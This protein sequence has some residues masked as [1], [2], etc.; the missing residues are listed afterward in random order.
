MF[1]GAGGASYSAVESLLDAGAKVNV[2]NRTQS[3]AVQMHNH[4][5]I[6]YTL[7][8]V[9]GVLSF[10]PP[11]QMESDFSIPDTAKFVFSAE[12]KQPSALL[13]KAKQANLLAVDGLAMLFYQGKRSFTLWTGREP[14]VTYQQFL[15]EIQ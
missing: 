11:C 10:L 5:G 15:G 12:Y 8:T 14:Q 7:P 2:V 4:F 1:L 6:N 3:K 9:D 13:T